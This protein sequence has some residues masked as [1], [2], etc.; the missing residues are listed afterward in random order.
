MRRARKASFVAAVLVAVALV[1]GYA[2]AQDAGS[3]HLSGTIDDYV[4]VEAMGPGFGAWHVSGA[5]SLHVKGTSG[6]A[7]F[8]ASILGVRSDLW[9][10]ENL[11][12]PATVSRSPHTHHVLISDG[13]VTSLSNGFRV[14]GIA[15]ITGNGNVA[16]YSNSP[17]EV[18][19]TGGDLIGF[20]NMKLTFF[21]DAVDHFG[22]QAY[23]GLVVLE[24]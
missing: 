6:K 14:S 19:I 21:E 2:S 16:D 11:F 20:S 7:D 8:A 24:P 1:G 3:T 12:D 13:Q 17:I 23:E 4:W 22:P 5:W 15:T 18:D 10:I 9:V